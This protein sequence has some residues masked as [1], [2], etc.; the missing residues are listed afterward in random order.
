MSRH[1]NPAAPAALG[2]RVRTALTGTRT[3]AVLSLGI[4]VGLGAVGTLAAWTDSATAT[5]GMFS[6]GSIILKLDGN[7][8]THAFTTLTKTGML[9]GDSVAQMLP[10]TNNGSTNFAYVAKVTA[11]GPTELASMLDVKVFAGGTANG[12]ACSGGTAAGSATMV[13]GTSVDLIAARTLAATTG[14]DN[15]CFQVSLKPTAT[16]AAQGKSVSAAFEFVATAAA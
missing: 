3:R 8:T 9:P 14:T 1:E 5:T 7:R 16:T 10:V 12:T 4:V 2:S 6:T 15:L 13:T 11:S